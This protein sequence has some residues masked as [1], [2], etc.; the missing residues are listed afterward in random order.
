M[1]SV[2]FGLRGKFN[3]VK[4]HNSNACVDNCVKLL[5]INKK[6]NAIICLSGWGYQQSKDIL[7][8]LELAENSSWRNLIVDVAR[9][10][11]PNGLIPR[12]V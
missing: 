5:K 10:L 4:Y 1:E 8:Y 11:C 2:F 9:L 3:D 7:N 12:P 6:H